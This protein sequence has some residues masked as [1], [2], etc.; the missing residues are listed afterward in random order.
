MIERCLLANWAYNLGM[1]TAVYIA[2]LFLVVEYDL[3][4]GRIPNLIIFGGLAVTLMLSLL[5]GVLTFQSSILGAV[6]GGVF[7][8]I[9]RG[10]GHYL[11]KRDA[12]GWGDVKLA[13]LLGAMVG[14][15][16]VL[17]V[18]ALGILLAGIVALILV[19]AKKVERTATLPY[20]VFLA[21]AGM[22]VLLMQLFGVI[23]LV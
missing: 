12:L 15:K 11:F 3:R 2:I 23:N 4:Q 22:V 9:L 6:V 17:W 18:L 20:G 16:A 13:I 10:L 5:A 19:L 1:E 21:T 8:A 7:L 14:V